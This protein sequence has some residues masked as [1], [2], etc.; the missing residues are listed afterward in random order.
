[1]LLFLADMDID[2]PIKKLMTEIGY[3]TT[4]ANVPPDD[5]EDLLACHIQELRRFF[6]GDEMSEMMVKLEKQSEDEKIREILE[7]YG[8]GFDDIYWEGKAEGRAEAIAENNLEIA[9]ICLVNGVSEDIISDCTGVS[10]SE[11]E[12]LKR[13]L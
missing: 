9:K 12:K 5:K 4:H 1:M 2:I 11:L 7:T 10:I 3:I 6:E 8:N 13:E